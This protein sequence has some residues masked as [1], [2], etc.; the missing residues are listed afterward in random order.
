[1][2]HRPQ[3]HFTA[4]AT[5]INDPNGLVRHRGRFHLF[6]Q[7]NPFG[8]DWGNMS[9]GHAVSD[10]LVRWEHLPI[11]LPKR[12][13]AA[14]GTVVDIFSGTVAPLSPGHHVAG[15]PQDA[16]LLACYTAHVSDQRGV[17]G[18][19]QELAWSTDDGLT[20][21]LHPGNPVLARDRT[22]FRD[23]RI[24]FDE[25]LERWVMLVAAPA[26]NDIE[27]YTSADGADWK[28][29][30]SVRHDEPGC[31]VECPD[32]ALLPI[33]GTDEARWVLMYS[34][35][36]L[37]A[38]GSG[39]TVY[40]VGDWHDGAFRPSSGAA[41]R[42]IDGG[43]DFYALQLFAGMPAGTPAL[44]I[45][46]AGGSPYTG[47]IP[48]SPW[49]GTLSMPR[50]FWL[51]RASDDGLALRQGPADE[52]RDAFGPAA[53]PAEPVDGGFVVRWR[54]PLAA[55]S[56]ASGVRIVDGHGGVLEVRVDAGRHVL[57][58]DR[59]RAGNVDFHP[60][61]AGVDE[62]ELAAGSGVVVEAFVDASIL[63]VF[64]ADGVAAITSLCFLAPG[65]LRVE[66]FGSV[67]ELGLRRFM[68]GTRPA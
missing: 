38:P 56:S 9:W 4:E 33:D 25:A 7:T 63:E 43:R 15:V 61:F 3:F 47:V 49:R 10:D 48:T 35:G 17:V 1:M 5:W 31:I 45:A 67:D 65:P 27:S 2:H 44:G 42:Q 54:S 16:E 55:G 40:L 23:P 37:D 53:D 59:T 50:R 39:R 52:V 8:A 66:P 60:L 29:T 41:P 21:T 64:V 28:L 51:A 11:A 13:G 34:I 68:A 46:W 62:V 20:W 30:G 19:L 6:F 57:G 26:Q 24:F 18:E 58:V 32:L 12:A 14:P 36:Y 22:D